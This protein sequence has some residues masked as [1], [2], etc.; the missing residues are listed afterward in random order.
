SARKSN[1][2]PYRTN[3]NSFLVKRCGLLNFEKANIEPILYYTSAASGKKIIV[4]A[5]LKA[6]LPP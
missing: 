5:K 2:N 3:Q 1:A 6:I 4:T